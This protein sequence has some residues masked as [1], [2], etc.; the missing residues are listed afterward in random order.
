[1]S[2]WLLVER[3]RL[4]AVLGLGGIGKTALVAH[5]A[6][7]LASQF[8]VVF[9]RSLRNA[10]PVEEWL[11]EAIRALDPARTP[12]PARQGA[13]LRLLLDLV[14][15][16]RGLL[17]LDNLETILRPG[18]REVRYRDG[19]EG[20]G[21]VLQQLAES[22]H[23]SCLLVTGREEPPELALFAASQAMVR[24]L[25][26]AGLEPEAGRTLLQDLR[27]AG[28]PSAWQTLIRRYGGNP[29]ALK[30]VGQTA[31]ELFGGELGPF[32]AYTHASQEAV[33]GGVRQLLDEQFERLSALERTL[34]YWLAV[35]RE[36]VRPEQLVADLGPEVGRRET[37]EA[38][39]A[40]RRRSLLERGSQ[41]G[42][43]TLQPVV[44]EYAT[45]RLVTTLA[46]EILTA[47]PALLVSH[48]LLQATAKEYVRRCQERM[49][50]R[51]LLERLGSGPGLE[52]RLLD[53]LGFWR[54]VPVTA[55]GYGPG[56]VVNLLRLQRGD[57]RG[58]DLSGLAIRQVYLQGVDAQDVNLAG[59]QLAETVLAE[60]F[61]H[62]ASVALS[63]DG[64]F[65]RPA[66]RPVR[67]ACG[68]LATA[69]RCSR[70]RAM[71]ALSSA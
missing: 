57:L 18:E 63:A 48:A 65:A 64:A 53:L 40:L 61:N 10:L 25:R 16:R 13:R 50:A 60:A 70:H 35:E 56:N 37:L 36:A 71:P 30:V 4:V 9:W 22:T 5:L 20:Y 15:E 39:E 44:L 49:I 1:M 34:V 2:R 46:Q 32:L 21:E 26:L 52:R 45:E 8:D 42:T 23:Q 59:S 7:Q 29:W 19:Y 68:G 28:D 27:L 24:T 58:V 69:P 54:H 55:D 38:L 11:A 43:L 3:C 33:F 66:H 14:R 6:Q 67:C 41:G 51:P 12:I 62:A 31:A 17:V 47:Q